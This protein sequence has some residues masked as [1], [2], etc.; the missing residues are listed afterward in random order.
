MHVSPNLAACLL[1]ALQGSSLVWRGVLVLHTV[2]SYC[3]SFSKD[4]LSG[5]PDIEPHALLLL[6][7]RAGW[8]CPTPCFTGFSFGAFYAG[9][10]IATMG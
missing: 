2:A 8:M 3:S 10:F 4:F 5:T 1:H 6:G 7:P 9:I